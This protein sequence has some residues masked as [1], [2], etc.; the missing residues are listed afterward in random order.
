MQ[1]GWTTKDQVRVN[2]MDE[3]KCKRMDINIDNLLTLGAQ[4][5]GLHA[6]VKKQGACQ[7]Q[8]QEAKILQAT[9]QAI[10]IQLS[11]TYGYPT[12]KLH[13]LN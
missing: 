10:F 11:T 3:E 12:S 6:K 7:N 8:A 9:P 2:G 13:S 4:G 1:K 5:K